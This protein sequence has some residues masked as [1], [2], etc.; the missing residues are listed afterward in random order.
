MNAAITSRSIIGH[1][2]SFLGFAFVVAIYSY[3][4]DYTDLF[5]NGNGSIPFFGKSVPCFANGCLAYRLST[6]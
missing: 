2:F 4:M 1:R 6:S 5:E 3:D